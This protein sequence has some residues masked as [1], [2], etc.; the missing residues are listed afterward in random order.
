MD[1]TKFCGK[2]FMSSKIENLEIDI[3]GDK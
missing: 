3:A 2:I 1:P